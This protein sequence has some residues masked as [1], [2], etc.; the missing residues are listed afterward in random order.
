MEKCPICKTKDADKKNVHL[1]PWFLIKKCITQGGSGE[2]DM[3]L[4]FSIDP[5]SFTKMY[6]GRSVLPENLEEFG[7]LNDFQIEKKNPYSRDYLV[8]SEC[9]DKFSRLEAIF[10]SQFNDKSLKSEYIAL[11]SNFK[12]HTAIINPKYN[13][14]LFELLIQS[15]FYRCSIGR[16]NGFKL[17]P[18]VQKKIEE[19]LCIAFKTPDF[20]KLKITDQL[21]FPK[22]FPIVV[23]SL[24]ISEREDPTKQFIVINNSRFPYFIMAGKWMFQIFEAEKHIKSSIEWFYGL[25]DKLSRFEAYNRIM[26]TSHVI[27]LD[28]VVS[29]Y[30]FQNLID[31]FAQRKIAGLK[32][33]ILDLHY[34][35][36]KNRPTNI[37]AQYIYTRYFI[38]LNSGKTEYKSLVHAFLD[39]KLLP[40][41]FGFWNRYGHN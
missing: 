8:C 13:S 35:I 18:A 4:S 36:F 1:I 38:H 15:I 23:Y 29:K 21:N 31:D 22:V 28:D 30:I 37:I 11:G 9:E 26:G 40:Y 6:S 39:L 20:K 25:N 2:R 3:E 32:K 10:A 7:E 33:T 19:N 24:P 41:S 16:F 17:H 12:E 27:I 5:T 34:H 14:S